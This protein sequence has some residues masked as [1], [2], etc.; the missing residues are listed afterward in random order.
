MAFG[1]KAK[2]APESF[3]FAHFEE[4]GGPMRMADDMRNL[5][6]EIVNS[7][8]AR[9]TRVK[10]LRHE[11]VAMLKGFREMH[12]GI[13][14]RQ[15]ERNREVAGMLAGFRRECEAAGSHWSNMAATMAK[16]RVTAT[17]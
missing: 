4:A 3:S 5:G 14:A 2:K 1:K 13:K 10:A 11:T 15:E 8:E 6:Q 12:Q 17:R 7:F 16:K 9:V